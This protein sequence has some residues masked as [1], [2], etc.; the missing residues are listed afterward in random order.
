MSED[1]QEIEVRLHQTTADFPYPKTPI[2]HVPARRRHSRESQVRL[3]WVAAVLAIV[4]IGMFAIPPI[5]AAVLQILQIG[6]VELSI[7]D[8]TVVPDARPLVLQDFP[9]ETTLE[10]ATDR[11]PFALYIPRDFGEPDYVF[12]PEIRNIGAHMVVMVWVAADDPT[13]IELA[14]YIFDP[15]VYVPK[16]VEYV[17]ETEVDGVFAVWTDHPHVIE[18]E[19]DSWVRDAAP[20]LVENNVLI[21][22][23]GHLTYRLE[24]NVSMEDAV[25]IAESLQRVE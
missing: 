13:E 14:L 22:V 5:R 18:L 11:L 12:V 20:V 7:G 16:N 17:A 23:R 25:Q 4:L 21:W 8:G 15:N 24:A 6:A 10:E 3:A 9:G 1:H 19:L 2:I